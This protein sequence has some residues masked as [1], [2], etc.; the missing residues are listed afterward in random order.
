MAVAAQ[1]PQ[2]IPVYA[3]MSSINPVFLLPNA[4]QTRAEQIGNAGNR[5]VAIHVR[6]F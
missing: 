6:I 1:R 2:P 5:R 4:L 3:E